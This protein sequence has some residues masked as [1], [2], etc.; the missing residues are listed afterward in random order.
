[1]PEVIMRPSIKQWDFLNAK[2]MYVAY[3]GAR[4]GG[5]SWVVRIAA[6]IYAQ[7]YPGSR[8]L[9]VRRTYEELKGNHRDPLRA[10]LGKSARYNM[11]DKEFIFPNGS[12]IVLSYYDNDGAAMHFQG[13]EYHVIYVDEAT[14]L[15]EEWIKTLMACCRSS[16]SYPKHMYFTMNP[17]GPGHQYFKRLFVDRRFLQGEEP[18]NYRFIQAKVNDNK[19]LM[20][21]MPQYV[22]FLDQ[23]PPKLKKAWRDGSWDIFEGQ[24]F[25]EFRDNEDGYKTRQWTHVI[26]DFRVPKHWDVWRAFDWGSRRP[27]SCGWYAIDTMG[28]VYRIA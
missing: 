1:M 4:G 11:Q 17:G 6:I 5:K 9:I 2:E 26:D 16:D 15:R 24:Y 12:R 13:Q 21:A 27:F 14:N 23:L 20:E 18:E 3:G 10:I 22:R 8:Q 19:A 7:K 25:E 28:T